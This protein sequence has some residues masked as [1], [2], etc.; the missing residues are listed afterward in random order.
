MSN[1]KIPANAVVIGFTGSI[2]S[3]CSEFSK[4]LQANKSYEYYSL[5][6]PIHEKAEEMLKGGQIRE[7]TQEVLQDIGNQLRREMGARVL[8][9][10][11]LKE[12]DERYEKKPFDKIV[13]DSLRN[14]GEVKVLREW[15][16]FYLFS[17]HANYEARWGRW[18]KLNSHKSRNDF[19]QIDKRDA[20]ENF[21][22]GQ[23]VKAC[24]DESDIALNNDGP[25]PNE[26]DFANPIA[27][28][29]YIDSKLSKYM[30]L[31]EKG[32]QL[33][34]RPQINEKLMTVAYMESLSSSCSQ[35]K[36]GAVIATN[37][38]DILSTGYNHVP[39]GEEPCLTAF[40]EC[41][42]K[43]LR[44]QN[45][46][47]MKHCPQCGKKIIQKCPSCGNEFDGFLP[48][49]TACGHDIKF[50]Y[51]CP[52]C[53]SKV[54]ETFTIGGKKSIG[55]GLDACRALHAEE[56]A[57]VNL[58]RTGKIGA[59]NAVLYSTTFPCT[60]CANKIVQSKIK[61]VV[62]GEPYTMID[63]EK[64]LQRKKIK[65][66]RFEGVKSTAFFRLYGT[67]LEVEK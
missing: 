58:A 2:S 63:A 6:K 48:S 42:R 66:E 54:F 11:A 36:V 18:S 38:G 7:I 57:I 40:G 30:T 65:T 25:N 46:E 10:L 14:L 19:E 32:P 20:E 8:V 39:E 62:Y 3:G 33:D 21:W 61:K 41:Y 49:C 31:I 27:R 55:K 45:A 26:F 5:S 64:L 53:H 60:L 9:E 24:C 12:L 15:P 22:Y 59:K 52:E 56:N 44:K 35:R 34:F 23:Q 17:I 47:L 4:W 29:K 67:T 37:E 28:S 13:I 16:R 51:E 50:S 1:A 43:H